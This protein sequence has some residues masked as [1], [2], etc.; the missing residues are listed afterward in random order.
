MVSYALDLEN[1]RE[2][3]LGLNLSGSFRMELDSVYFSAND[4]MAMS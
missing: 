2:L 3:R 1:N 4:S